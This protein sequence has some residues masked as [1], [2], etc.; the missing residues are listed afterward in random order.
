S[1]TMPHYKLTYF[2]LR[3]RGE[4]IRMMFAIADVPL[5]EER[6][7]FQDW[8]EMVKTT[9]FDA[10]PM[11]EVDGFK[12]AQSLAI[13]RYI[14]RDTGY[15]GP[16]NLTSAIGDA[17]ADQYA[18]FVTT[19]MDWHLANIGFGPGD[20]DAL[21]DSVYLPAKA[22]NFPFFE[23][24]LKKS[25]T[26]WYANTS[27]LTHVDVFIAAGLEWLIRLDKNAKKI[28]EEYPLMGA[29]YKKLYCLFS[30]SAMPHYKL[31]YFDLRARGECIRMMF[32]I[33]GVP[34]EETRIPMN[35][36]PE[37]KKTFPFEAVPVLEVDGVPVAQTLSILRYIAR[38][39]GY[40]GPDNLSSALADALADQYADFVMAFVPW[41]I[42]NAGYAPGD[43]DALYESVYLPAKAKHLPYFEAALR[44]STTGWYANTPELTH[45]DVFIAS[46]LE[47][48]MR[49]DKNAQKI[50]EEYPLL[51]AHSE[52]F[53]AHPK[54]QKYLEERPDARGEGIRM[55]FAIGGI[56]LEDKRIGVEEWIEMVK[57][58]PFD[59]LPMLEVDGVKISQ[60]LAILRYIARETGYAGPDNLSAAIADALADQYADFVM[61]FMPWHL[62][63]AGYAP[64]DKDALYD[65]VYVPARA[66]HLPFFEAALKKSTTGWYANTLEI[67]H[68]DVFIASGLEWLM[69][70]DK[71]AQTIFEE[72]PL[73]KAHSEKFFAHPKLQ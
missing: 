38:E 23:A 45:A 34:L 61:A 24:A 19:F 10:L 15:F 43:K 32:A 73:I 48:L 31:T 7:Q 50:F 25:T 36:W 56:P 71:N 27:E 51:K 29:Q 26:G 16:D 12:F 67:T 21:Y 18:D 40:A 9:P 5:E 57:T 47:W 68:A 65:S 64:G 3:G 4:C 13:L 14:A 39:A 20:K 8:E 22:K 49:L 2:D 41:H 42:V 63:N 6:V 70:M 72:F 53:F 62:V 46:G 69:R 17:L 60:T 35:E 11:L 33:A 52:K 55:M 28:F 66:K 59:A 54:L 44:K 37:L 58:T 1:R 30:T